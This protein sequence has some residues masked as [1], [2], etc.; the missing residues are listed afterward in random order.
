MRRSRRTLIPLAALL[1]LAATVVA[2]PSQAA[3]RGWKP[4]P[5]KYGDVVVQ[6]VHIRMSDGVELVGDVEYPADLATGNAVNGRF[7]VLLTQNPYV[8]SV[9]ASGSN[10]YYVGRGYI[11]A[12]VCVRGAG[13][14][15]GQF[16]FMGRPDET[17]R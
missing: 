6:N 8:C 16:G 12:T 14:S 3:P 2:V 11:F 9:P 13:R 10:T 17:A 1:A 7:P 4:D 5:V 15:G